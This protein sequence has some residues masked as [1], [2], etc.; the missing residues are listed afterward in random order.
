[1][2]RIFLAS[3]FSD[4]AHLLK[5]FEKEDLNGKT[6]TFIPTASLAEMP[7]FF[8]KT[9]IKSLEELG[10]TV[11][12]LEV[13]EHSSE[14]IEN[15]ITSNNYIYVSG[16]NTFFLYKE[17]K[18]KKV[19]EMIKNHILKGKLYIG[20]SAGT[21]ILSPNIKYVKLMDNEK[22]GIMD[23]NYDA[24]NIIDFYPVPHFGNFPFK[25]KVKKIIKKYDNLN[26]IPFSNNQA[27]LIK[28]DKVE[29][30]QS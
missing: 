20:E 7:R 23:N 8:V 6:V 3:F 14:E 18:K 10:L 25:S 15:K 1:M 26:L 22:K 21:M 13:T 5:D 30:V 19:D 2:K 4:V 29:I 27:I 17:L 11:D 28:G 9:A 24:L 12:I 16:G